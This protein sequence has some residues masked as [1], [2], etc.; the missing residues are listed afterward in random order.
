MINGGKLIARG[1]NSCVIKP[2][3]P[4]D[5]KEKPSNKKVSK[6]IYDEDSKSML[7][8]EKKQIKLVKEIKGY[9]KWAII[10]DEF[11]NTPKYS[12]LINY[13]KKA[14][15]DCLSNNEK[16]FN[17]LNSKML[18][19]NAG[20]LTLYD[21]FMKEFNNVK[22]ISSFDQKFIKLM[23]M[24][25]P[26]FLGLKEMYNNDIVH[27]DIKYNNIVIHNGMF[28]YIDFGLSNHK[29]NKKEFRN[30]SSEESSLNRIYIFYPI[31]YIFYNT[32]IFKLRFILNNIKK[33]KNYNQYHDLMVF[34]NK[35]P[36]IT[37]HSVMKELLMKKI[38]EEEMISKIDVYSLGI[39]IPLL[40]NNSSVDRDII[41]GSNVA[42]KFFDLFQD[43]SE[44]FCYNRINS[45][46]A[47]DT[48]MKLIDGL[49]KKK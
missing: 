46:E 7:N 43:M 26:L 25:K 3:I 22:N 44:P 6:I 31:E 30:R 11:C 33:R 38:N 32:N 45:Q 1:S 14:I 47:Y 34:F 28:K 20:G 42:Y 37:V 29:T 13:D 19:G 36:I 40:L 17:R 16:K 35:I 2:S 21:Y 49:K 12:F 18:I 4:C 9:E 10:F 27:N 48:Y 41:N 15:D 39:L 23:K 5:K 8:H 24:M